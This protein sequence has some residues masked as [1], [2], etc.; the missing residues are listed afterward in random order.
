[1]HFILLVEGHTERDVLGDFLRRWLNPQLSNGNVGIKL[2]KLHG[3]GEFRNKMRKKALSHL[4]GPGKDKIIAVIGM[5]DLYGP[6][7][8][9]FY[10][11]PA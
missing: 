8:S 9:N 2:V 4:K 3:F 7:H 10:P 11:N 1:M 6:Q 5:L